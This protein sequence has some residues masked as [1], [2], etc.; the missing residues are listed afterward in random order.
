MTANQSPIELDALVGDAPGYVAARYGRED[1]TASL[2]RDLNAAGF[3]C[4]TSATVTAC[5]RA[6]PAFA[7]CF[8]V[9]SVTIAAGAPVHAEVNRRCMGAMPPPSQP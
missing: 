1:F 3:T 6:A 8:D 5:S 9:W 4:Q 2:T 7:S